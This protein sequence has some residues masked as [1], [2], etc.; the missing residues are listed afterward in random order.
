MPIYSKAGWLQLRPIINT[1]ISRGPAR[2]RDTHYKC[3]TRRQAH[4]RSFIAVAL[5]IRSA[6]PLKDPGI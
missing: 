5:F 4:Q 6:F 2:Y 3:T 1:G